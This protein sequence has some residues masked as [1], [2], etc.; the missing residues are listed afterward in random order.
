MKKVQLL[1]IGATV[2]GTAAALRK[3]DVMIIEN[4]MLCGAEF[5]QAY[6]KTKV[7]MSL[8]SDVSELSEPMKNMNIISDDGYVHLLPVGGVLASLLLKNDIDVS[9]FTQVFE[10]KKTDSGFV[11]KVSNENGIETVFAERI[12]D[13]TSNGSMHCLFEE[14]DVR[15]S[16]CATL[17]GPSGEATDDYSFIRGR[18]DNETI[19]EL[20][21]DKNCTFG[22]ARCKI[23]KL[24]Q[25]IHKKLPKTRFATCAQRFAYEFPEAVKREVM[26]GWTWQPSVSYGDLFTAFKEGLS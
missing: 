16:V 9:F 4:S 20:N 14:Y 17:A 15:K 12:L 6:R 21:V 8:I 1:I 22:E 10:I 5:V 23:N 25:D 3:K 19:L 7:D 2:L 18:F 13:T 24:W 11:I 26:P